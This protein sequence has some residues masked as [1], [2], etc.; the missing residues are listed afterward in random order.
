MEGSY[1]RQRTLVPCPSAVGEWELTAACTLME[2]DGMVW[3]VDNEER[4]I[5]R[6]SLRKTNKRLCPGGWQETYA[7]VC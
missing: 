6:V 3:D 5:V 4:L 7:P 2:A 1:F